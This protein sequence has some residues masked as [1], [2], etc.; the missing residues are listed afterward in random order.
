[1]GAFITGCAG[2]PVAVDRFGN[3]QSSAQV[4]Q[5]PAITSAFAEAKTKPFDIPDNYFGLFGFN[6]FGFGLIPMAFA[7]PDNQGGQI[8]GFNTF[9][10]PYNLDGSRTVFSSGNLQ[11]KWM[12]MI[13]GTF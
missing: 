6:R 7:Q 13:N 3:M 4:S 1:V 5:P 12:P 8:F 9:A 2:T 11:I 10:M